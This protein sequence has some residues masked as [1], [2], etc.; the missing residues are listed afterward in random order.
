MPVDSLIN[1]CYIALCAYDVR[2][3][4]IRSVLM[5][6]HRIAYA[7]GLARP[8][9]YLEFKS[10]TKRNPQAQRRDKGGLFVQDARARKSN[11]TIKREFH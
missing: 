9:F 8:V 4:Y 5:Y 10:F 6:T 11:R 2:I 1:Y 3:F 7:G